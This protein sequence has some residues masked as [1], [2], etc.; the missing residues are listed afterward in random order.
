MQHAAVLLS[1]PDFVEMAAAP[2][3]MF[4]VLHAMVSSSCAYLEV[5]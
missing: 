5:F 3:F 1:D 2:D 4:E